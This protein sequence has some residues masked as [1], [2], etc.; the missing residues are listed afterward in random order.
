MDRLPSHDS[1][2]LP[3]PQRPGSQRSRITGR[4]IAACA[5]LL[6]LQV[7]SQAQQIT[8]FSA[9]EPTA[10]TNGPDGRLWFAMG[11]SSFIQGIG[12]ITPSGSVCGAIAPHGSL[13]VAAGPD[14]NIWFIGRE[15]Y[16]GRVT[17][18]G[19]VTEFHLGFLAGP[20]Q[21]TAGPDG[22]IWITDGIRNLILRMTPSGQ[23]TEFTVPTPR[24]GVRGITSGPDSNVWF[25]EA[26]TGK[27]GRI[28][29]AGVV[30][31]FTLAPVSGPEF[32]APGPDG[33]LWFTNGPRIGRI[34][35]QG[36][37]T[38]YLVDPEASLKDLVAGPDGRIWFIN[39]GAAPLPPKI[40]RVSL[41]GAI[42][43]FDAPFSLG[44]AAGSDGNIW[45]TD[46][47]GMRIG[48][49]SVA[50]LPPC[51][52]GSTG[53][54]LA[55]G[56]FQVTVH[57]RG[58]PG[59]IRQDGRPV[60]LTDD[61][62]AFWF[63]NASNLE[64]VLKVLDGRAINGRFWVFYGSLTNVE[65][66]VTVTDTVTG[67]TKTYMNAQGQQASVADTGAF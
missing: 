65:F 29:T 10:I 54:C 31:E 67:A 58:R 3:G 14:G 19:A 8:Y 49:L 6:L 60:P 15:S 57:F 55:G 51:A 50:G 53:L 20:N 64:L 1:V 41:G 36:A 39:N 25:T 5:A 24:A 17:P 23:V 13:E 37:V 63:F 42:T 16:I 34:T 45:F 33:N 11:L 52:G 56:R 59:E 18:A 66:D 32:I 43:Q 46:P 30:T 28:T 4:S 27:I 61:T 47:I 2:Y 21:L 38:E 44:I 12:C 22:N 9:P 40:G 7:T 48:R 35:P 62:G 26:L